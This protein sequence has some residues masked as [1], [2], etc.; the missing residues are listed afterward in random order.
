MSASPIAAVWQALWHAHD[1]TKQLLAFAVGRGEASA[2]TTEGKPNLT[3]EEQRP[4]SRRPAYRP[5]QMIGL[6]L[7]PTLFLAIMA[8]ATPTGMTPEAKAVLASTLW[9]A[10][11]WITEAIPIPATSLLPIILFP[12]TGA[13]ETKAVT[14]A[15]GN[16]TIFLFLGGFLIALAMERWNLHKRIALSIISVIGTS[17]ERIVLGFMVSTG[18]LSMWIS[19]TA[20]AMMMVPIGTAIIYQVSE[21]FAREHNRI[22]KQQDFKFGKAMMLGIAYSASIGGL[23]TLIGTPPNT[24]LAAVVDEMYGVKISFATWMLFGVP[25]VVILLSLA[26]L[27]LV[28]VAFKMETKQLPGGSKLIEEQKEELGRATYE[29]KMVFAVFITAAF[30]WISRSF[31]INKWLPAVDDTIIA[32]FAAAVLFLIPSRNSRG[33][34]LLDWEVTK[35]L[36]WGIL[37]LFGGGLAIAAG[38]K[39]TGLAD[40]IGE[41]L[42]VMQGVHFVLILA[43]VTALVIFLTEITSNTATAT[44]IL[45]IMAALATAMNVH[46]Y[47]LMIPAAIAASCAFMLPVA[48]PPN[49]V[50]FAANYLKMTD[51]AKAGFWINIVSVIIIVALVYFWL[52]VSWGIDLTSFPAIFKP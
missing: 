2:R 9:I 1:R 21:A 20:T 29:E 10:T 11:W 30:L 38:F 32:I 23:G 7:G 26:W 46:P 41:Q 6:V 52:P 17:T 3:V 50:V 34:F 14:A 25:L 19:N 51:M 15:Y 28:K 24:I 49:A 40:W 36:P 35:Q 33:K 18:F 44:M 22:I 45:P 43:V 8:I 5:A 13:L 42:T 47:S 12:L 16:D 27:Y 4:P 37:L 48:T 39:E 31:L